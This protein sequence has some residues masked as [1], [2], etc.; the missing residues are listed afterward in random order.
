MEKKK[1]IHQ[2]SKTKRFELRKNTVSFVI[3]NLVSELK[4]SPPLR[5][6]RL[7]FDFTIG[8]CRVGLPPRN[9]ERDGNQQGSSSQEYPQDFEYSTYKETPLGGE[10]G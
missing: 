7:L 1:T 8:D 10:V 9:D 6:N 3:A 4:Q 5:F 2:I